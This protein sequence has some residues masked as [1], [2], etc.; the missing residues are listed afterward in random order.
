M[1]S[2]A[3]YWLSKIKVSYPKSRTMLRY[4][5]H[6]LIWE[7]FPGCPQGTPQPFLFTICDTAKEEGIDCLVQ[8]LTQPR[9]E[10]VGLNHTPTSQELMLIQGS[11]K[12]VA[13]P[14]AKDLKYSFRLHA[15]PIKNKFISVT[16]RGRKLPIRDRGEIEKWLLR[17]AVQ[18]GFTLERF[19]FSK[20][21]VRT[22][23]ASATNGKY[24]TIG[25][26]RF[27]G[28]LRITDTQKFKTSLTAGIGAK[29]SFGLGML[30][31]A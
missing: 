7:A 21:K 16:Q 23:T 11:Y 12:K 9:W 24:Y 25:V 18:N 28:T 29:K 31:I 20:G 8:S 6:R 13:A 3:D 30:M 22:R 26:C 27:D 10:Q 14:I 2:Q 15:A 19:E 4:N 17:K 1:K 5:L